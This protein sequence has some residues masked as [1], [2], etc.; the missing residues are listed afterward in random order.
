M[1]ESSL[2]SADEF[3]CELSVITIAGGDDWFAGSLLGM[4]LEFGVIVGEQS[5]E[6]TRV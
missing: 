1:S 3:S 6:V 2:S 4:G 5:G